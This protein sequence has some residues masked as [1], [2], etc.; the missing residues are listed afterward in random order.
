MNP[1]PRQ[2]EVLKLAA[3]GL[4]NKEIAVRLGLKERTVKFH[5]SELHKKIGAYGHCGHV[6]IVIFAYEK[7]IV[8]PGWMKFLRIATEAK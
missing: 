7:G 1:S 6:A 2:N 5:I 8:R 4:C 3:R